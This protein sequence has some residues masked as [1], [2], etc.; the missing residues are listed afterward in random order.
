[1]TM[2]NPD[3]GLGATSVD[4]PAKPK[5]MISIRSVGGKTCVKINSSSLALI[6]ECPRKTFYS[7]IEGWRSVNEAPATLFGRAIHAA[8]EVYY[9]GE[10]DER[11]LP[12]L[13][14]CE[15]LAFGQ[16]TQ[17]NNDLIFRAIE[18]Y[19]EVA[20]PLRA[21]PDGDKRST[22]NG[23]WILHEYFKKFIDDPYVAFKDEEG[24]FVERQFSVVV[25]E[26]ESLIIELFG[27]I[28]FVLRHMVTG[29]LLPG[30]HKTS[31]FLT[32]GDSSYYDRDKPNHQYTGYM[33]GA[34]RAFGVK[35]EDF[36]VNVIEVK[37]RP[38]TARGSGPNFPRQL[39][40]RTEEDF[41]E[42]ITML[43]W[44][45]RNFLLMRERNVWPMGPV[46]ICNKY[47][48][49]PFKQVCASPSSIR[50]TILKNKFSKELK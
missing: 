14:Q 50:E 44:N 16:R 12:S 36:C 11:V 2:I 43:E 38:K 5:E 28:D 34:T 22:L 29:A 24:P 1:M 21:L 37:G 42:F 25:F 47:G 27:T 19:L 7:L 32:F 3:L 39:T 41:A 4:V 33:L 23:V 18:A 10:P 30:D 8:L 31:S 40:R 15:K 46:D 17:T 48:G 35:S 6:Q 49:C 45:V 20:E 13:E 9:T 26:D